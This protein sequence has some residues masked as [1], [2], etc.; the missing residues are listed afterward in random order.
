[1]LDKYTCLWEAALGQ[2]GKA[3]Q[4]ALEQAGKAVQ[5]TP[6][7]NSGQVVNK[8]WTRDGR[9]DQDHWRV[10]DW[11]SNVG[12]GSRGVLGRGDR[13]VLIDSWNGLFEWTGTTTGTSNND[14]ATNKPAEDGPSNTNGER[15]DKRLWAAHIFS[16]STHIPIF[17]DEAESSLR[18]LQQG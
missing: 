9:R 1:M 18:R 11:A 8:Q 7:T 12:R 16:N 10:E 17:V 3:V 14:V 15:S 13:L 6:I 2:A 4:A 5:A